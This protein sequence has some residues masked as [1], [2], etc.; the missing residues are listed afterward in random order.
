MKLQQVTAISA[1]VIAA[2]G[3]GAG[4]AYAGPVPPSNVRYQ[5]AIGMNGRSIETVLD[6]G[7]FRLGTSGHSVDVVNNSGVTVD[8]IPLVYAV[9]G[10]QYAIAPS[11]DR[12]SRRLILTP[13]APTVGTLAR[14]AI[15]TA[16]EQ[17]VGDN[18]TAYSNL[19]RQV[20]IGWLDGA[21]SASVG[22]GVGAVV[23]CML[24]L[25]SA[26]IPGAVL[27][28]ALGGYSGLVSANPE[29]EPAVF[30]FVDTLG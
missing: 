14:T 16:I 29:L 20:E 10:A 4:T 28:G 26:C 19:I 9:D 21:P 23:G 5:T 8:R 11:I 2:M 7:V 24:F 6:S 13:V 3:V 18:G 17:Q 22:A 25:I 1:L 12:N 27:G 30:E 15:R